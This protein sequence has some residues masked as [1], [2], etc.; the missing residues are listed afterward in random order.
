[1]VFNEKEDNN[2]LKDKVI[3]DLEMEIIINSDIEMEQEILKGKILE[4][5]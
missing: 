5:F 2:S 4:L 1:M 3:K